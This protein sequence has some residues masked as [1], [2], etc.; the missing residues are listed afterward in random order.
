MAGCALGAES[1][2]RLLFGPAVRRLLLDGRVVELA[3][4]RDLGL[5]FPRFQRLSL[6]FVEIYKSLFLLGKVIDIHVFTG[7]GFHQQ[8]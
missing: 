1:F 4:T 8:K 2:P 6:R 5:H 3:D 7:L